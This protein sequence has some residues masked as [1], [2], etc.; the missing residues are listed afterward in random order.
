MAT[1]HVLRR[2]SLATTLITC[3]AAC[4]ERGTE[5]AIPAPGGSQPSAASR[6][7]AAA[8]SRREQMVNEIATT[9][10][11]C[12]YEGNTLQIDPAAMDQAAPDDCRA[13]VDRIMD[14][15]GLPQNF[16]VTAGPVP[17]AMAAI[18]LDEQRI[19]RRVIAFNPDFI[20]TVKTA[21]G[22]D[23]WA[24]ISIMAHEIGHHL[25]GHTITEGH[26][27]PQIE[28]EAD[29]FSG[30][31]LYKMGA[32]LADSTR[33]ILAIGSPADQPTH[34]GRDRRAAAITEGWQEACQQAGADCDRSATAPPVASM[35]PSTDT[36]VPQPA[37][38]PFPAPE[39]ARI[40]FKYGRFVIDEFAVLDADMVQAMERR[41]FELARDP[42]I[43]FTFIVARDLHGLGA[44]D[45]AWA[46]MRQ[47]RVGKLDVG[48][49]AVIVVAP[50]A[51]QAAVAFGPGI[52]KEAEFSNPEQQLLEWIDA[53]WSYCSDDDGCGNWTG[54]LFDIFRPT[55]SNASN[56]HWT[57][58]FQSVGDVIAFSKAS[59]TDRA[60]TG[61]A[62]DDTVDQ[63]LGR[64]I[65]FAGE[66]TSLQAPV[67]VGQ[68]PQTVLDDGY[69]A[70]AVRADDGFPAIVYVHPRT[71]ALMPGG[72]PEV[73]KRYTFVG[74][75]QA[76][77][78]EA[79][80]QSTRMW[81]F[82]YEPV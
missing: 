23:D 33:A 13:M 43:E 29:K 77:G 53:A 48:N 51:R 69:Q 44:E 2:L 34:P 82:S 76:T 45:Y 61:R 57:I 32:P 8:E 49:G 6:T 28:L 81:L 26:S 31:V 60:R 16:V 24:P 75:L 63:P 38:M 52:A 56:T 70:I 5:P 27:R 68:T 78:D 11:A 12:S 54:N 59:E 7:T 3:L 15:T 17:N 4:S 35:P 50:E 40:P 47:L 9:L 73:G 30:Y 71:I 79:K 19:P 46:M 62:F 67:G 20:S 80:Q 42:G 72:A 22:G 41:L 10:Q 64:L 21:A 18:M 55:L 39:P 66:I 37:G 25:S 36:T 65:R 1:I 58:R 74:R 14:Y